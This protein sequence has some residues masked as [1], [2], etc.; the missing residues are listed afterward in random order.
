MG[1]G[2]FSD[3]RWHNTF[4]WCTFQVGQCRLHIHLARTKAFYAS[5]PKI[6]ENCSCNNCKYFED[7]IIY[8]DNNLFIVL[9]KMGADLSRQP[10]VNPDGVCCVGETKPGKIGYMGNYFVYGQ[11]GKTTKDAKN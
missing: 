3:E 7:E 5:Q 10:N 1:R 6:T 4:D 9:R 8:S 2:Y 11:I